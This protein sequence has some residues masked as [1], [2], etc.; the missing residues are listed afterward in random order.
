[1]VP[2]NHDFNYGYERLLELT[3][4]LELKPGEQKLRVL[5]S[6]VKKDGKS[7]F[8]PSYIKEVNGVKVGFF[9]VST[10]ETAYKTNPNN[11]K[12]LKFTSPIDSAKEEVKNLKANG[13]EVI[14]GLSH[15][16]IDEESSPTTY[17]IAK[18]VDDIDV[19]VDGH[20]HTDMLNGEKIND[21]LIVSTGS[22]ME[23]IGKVEIEVSNKNGKYEVINTKG[24]QIKKS[25]TLN[26]KGDPSIENKINEIKKSQEAILSTEIGETA[27]NLD[28]LRENVR[29]EE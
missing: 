24:S 22:Y 8:T 25:A 28:G 3:K 26:I 4:K 11:V 27:T 6:N 16:G 13:A 14:V 19:I 2:G 20:S 21:T 10:E 15:V 9:G 5:S 7:V 29:T 12:G 23:N 17:D 1:M 18:S